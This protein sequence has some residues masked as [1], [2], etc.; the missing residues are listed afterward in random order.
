MRSSPAPVWI[1]AGAPG[2][3]KTT[4]ADLLRTGLDPRPA[5]LDKDV[6]F[7]GFVTEVQDAHGRS[8]GEREGPW[9]DEHVKIHEYTGMTRAAAQIRASGCPV[10]LVA[11]FTTQIHDPDRWYAWIADLGGPPVELVWV[12]L[13]PDLLRRRLEER[14]SPLDTGKLA[15]WETFVERM[16]P[17][18]PPP[19]PHHRIDT[20]GSMDAV[21][22]QISALT[23]PARDTDTCR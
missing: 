5:L 22:R 10:M 18:T 2:A 14:G 6:L 20:S 13:A 8:R 1:V 16:Q 21:R 7:A 4:V 23:S 9:Y 11:P 15:D 12:S 3:G 19:V 17:T